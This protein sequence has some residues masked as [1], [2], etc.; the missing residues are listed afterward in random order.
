MPLVSLPA[1][2]ATRVPIDADADGNLYVALPKAPDDRRHLSEFA[3]NGSVLRFDAEGRTPADQSSP[4]LSR[5][6]PLPSGLV[7]DGVGQRVWLA[8]TGIET[9]HAAVVMLGND[10]RSAQLRVLS[11]TGTAAPGSTQE[12]PALALGPSQESQNLWLTDGGLFRAATQ[13]GAIASWQRVPT[14]FGRVSSVATYGGE[15]VLVVQNDP[16]SA[17][18]AFDIV[19]LVARQVH[20]PR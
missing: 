1:G 14:A 16:A 11:E 18:G 19:R 8:G 7:H 5:G 3:Y 4:V 9:R 12:T 10:P 17:A 20:D 13:D 6:Y 2:A 15:L